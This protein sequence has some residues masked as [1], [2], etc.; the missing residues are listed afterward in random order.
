MSLAAWVGALASV[1]TA[2]ARCLWAG[3]SIKEGTGASTR[4]K[5]SLDLLAAR[6]AAEFPVSGQ[7]QSVYRPAVYA[8]PTSGWPTNTAW[9]GLWVTS[10]AGTVSQQLSGIEGFPGTPSS[11]FGPGLRS[12]NLTST[13]ATATYTVHGTALDVWFAAGGAFQY[14]VDGGAY[15]SSISTSGWNTNGQIQQIALGASGTHTISI[16]R[17]S[18]TVRLLGFTEFDG[19]RDKGVA[20]FDA[21]HWGAQT[22]DFWDHSNSAAPQN[23][24]FTRCIELVAPQ[25]VVINTLINDAGNIGQQGIAEC[26]SRL[27]GILGAIRAAA[28]GASVVFL[29]PYD[30]VPITTQLSD[31]NTIADLKAA[32]ADWVETNDVT[33]IDLSASMPP[34]YEDTDGNYQSDGMHLTDAGHQLSADLIWPQLT[35][36]VSGNTA[37]G[38]AVASSAAVTGMASTTTAATG[39]AFAAMATVSATAS[40]TSIAVGMTAA[41]APRAIGAVT[42]TARAQGAATVLGA[43]VTG[44]AN[45]TTTGAGATAAPAVVV[46]GTASVTSIA[47]GTVVAPFA[48]TAGAATVAMQ[49]AGV[50]AAPP[51]SAT[52][53]AEAN[54]TTTASAAVTSPNALAS[55]TASTTATANVVAFAPIATAAGDASVT[56]PTTATIIAF[57]PRAG[58]VGYATSAATQPSTPAR[59]VTFA[60]EQRVA[61]L[62]RESRAAVF[63]AERRTAHFLR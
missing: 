23:A 22:I 59:T 41:T 13:N 31:G 63:A 19:A 37:I 24:K 27:T 54:D 46:M 32:V 11:T 12:V 20:I 60:L 1:G 28:P 35:P 56:T 55:G 45:I 42:V 52:G 33:L 39:A 58:A 34:V 7:G 16:R 57:A 9:G 3:D 36:A 25:L 8:C 50:A 48:S 38:A 2:Q 17:A 26:V 6:F 47:Q 21:C 15:S 43:S 4:A 44:H 51:A 5:R 18:G 10:S 53:Y 40:T 62:P 30:Q 61:A 49:A 29:Q 14:S